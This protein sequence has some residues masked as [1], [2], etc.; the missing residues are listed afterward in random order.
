MGTHEWE[1][2]TLKKKTNVNFKY[3]IESML[4]MPH[5]SLV[6]TVLLDGCQSDVGFMWKI[7]H[8]FSCSKSV[9]A[10]VNN[11]ARA[12][13]VECNGKGILGKRGAISCPLSN[14]SHQP[15][16]SAETTG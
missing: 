4:N 14:L 5:K 9:A 7:D 1:E 13:P 12:T 10:A 8:I 15:K 11:A 3:L 2:D 16:S 6:I